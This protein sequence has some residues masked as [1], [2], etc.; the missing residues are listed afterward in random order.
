[1]HIFQ[2]KAKIISKNKIWC[3][4][5]EEYLYTADKLEDLIHILNT[6][7]EHERHLVG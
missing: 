5:H 3:C 7:W 4:I 1:M 6:E 2:E